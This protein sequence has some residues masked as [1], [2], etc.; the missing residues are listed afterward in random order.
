MTISFQSGKNTFIQEG[1]SPAEQRFGLNLM[2]NVMSQNTDKEKRSKFDPN[3]HKIAEV[4]L[5]TQVS[6]LLNKEQLTMLCGAWNSD[7]ISVQD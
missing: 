7:E 3:V 6:M 1:Q 2:I 4:L 5:I